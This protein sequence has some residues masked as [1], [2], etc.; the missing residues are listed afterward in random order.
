MLSPTR[1]DPGGRHVKTR[2]IILRL[3][4]SGVTGGH[5]M[6]PSI[7]SATRCITSFLLAAAAML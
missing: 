6:W 2:W 3:Y 1:V 7:Q 5:F 4:L